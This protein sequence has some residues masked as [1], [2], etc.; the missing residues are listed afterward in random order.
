MIEALTKGLNNLPPSAAKISDAAFPFLIS[1]HGIP[2]DFSLFHC[3][4]SCE[5]LI[6]FGTLDGPLYSSKCDT[7][8]L[9]A[10]LS[11]RINSFDST[12]SLALSVSGRHNKSY[13][14]KEN[15]E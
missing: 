6:Y 12:W 3:S 10:S 5:N 1:R 7:G 9:H 11:R 15:T 4:Y 8:Q 2:W 14:R 13:C